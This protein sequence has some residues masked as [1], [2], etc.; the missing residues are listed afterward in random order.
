MATV[1]VCILI[2]CA[3]T[4]LR[5]HKRVIQAIS[6]AHA[7]VKITL[8]NGTHSCIR[9]ED[10]HFGKELVV[11]TRRICGA[12]GDYDEAHWKAL[13]ADG[14]L[15]ETGYANWE[16]MGANLNQPSKWDTGFRPDP[17]IVEVVLWTGRDH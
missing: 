3:Y 13:A 16:V 6:S 2:L 4:W 17:R 1:V 10:A 14:D 11:S 7:P 9:I 12:E 5:D 8:L 15:I